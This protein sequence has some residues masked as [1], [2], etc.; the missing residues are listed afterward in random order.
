MPRPE[1]NH[2]ES[3]IFPDNYK[4]LLNVWKTREYIYINFSSIHN[5]FYILKNVANYIEL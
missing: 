4:S 1:G 3:R 2:R 5:H